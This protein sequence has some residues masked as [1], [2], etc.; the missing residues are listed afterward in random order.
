MTALPQGMSAV[1][2]DAGT[3]RVPFQAFRAL[4]PA[5]ESKRGEHAKR[6]EDQ[7]CKEACGRRLSGT[8]NQRAA[9][10]GDQRHNQERGD[11]D[12]RRVVHD[13]TVC[14]VRVASVNRGGTA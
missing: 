12:Q 6:T 8:A 2:A 14:R 7:S 4:A 11:N 10:A 13:R 5:V 3:V 1:R 9:D